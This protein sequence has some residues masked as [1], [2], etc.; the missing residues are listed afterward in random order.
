MTNRPEFLRGA[1]TAGLVTAAAPVAA[2]SPVHQSVDPPA[3]LR[4][5]LAS[6]MRKARIPGMQVAVAR[7]GKVI[8]AESFG[9]ADVENAVPVTRSTVFQIASCAKAFVAVALMQL[10]ESG[11]LDLD[12]PASLYLPGLPGAWQ[13]VTVAELASHTSGLPDLVSNLNTLSL[14]VHGDAGASWAKVQTMPLEFA[15]GEKFNYVQTNYVLLGKIT[16]V[17]AGEPFSEF[18]RKRQLDVVGMSRTVYGD[19]HDVVVHSARTYTP[20]LV[21]DGKSVRTDTLYKTYIEFPPML[22]TCGGLNSSAEEMTHWLIA[23]ERAA[24]LSN[25]SSMTALWTARTLNDGKPGPWGVGGWVFSRS[26][27]PVF[28]SVG[29]AKAAFALYPSD[30]LAIVALTNL[31]ADLWLPFIDG[32]AANFLPGPPGAA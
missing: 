30:D 8:F 26:S 24:L 19:D 27:H 6:E 23:L 31:S 32:I 28:F 9:L 22:R 1:A 2:M 25:K 20:Y 7:H 10:V 29:A 11:K 3:G 16:D 15:P 5:H 17:L 14:I 21:V 13:S 12:A 18:I 4:A